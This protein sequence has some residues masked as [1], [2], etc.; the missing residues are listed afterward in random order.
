MNRPNGGQDPDVTA[1]EDLSETTLDPLTAA[2]SAK[3]GAVRTLIEVG[4]LLLADR[5]P[6]EIL[7]SILAAVVAHLQ[8]ERACVLS[9][10]GDGTIR[11]IAT[12]ALDLSGPQETWPLSRTALERVRN[13]GLALLAT[14][15]ISDPRF[16]SSG[17]V[18]RYSI[19]SVLCVPLGPKPARGLVYLDRRTSQS[20]FKRD[21]LE[22]LAAT[23]VHAASAL[24]KA[25]QRLQTV[26]ALADSAER[27]TLL[28][29]ELLRH[30][31]I[32]RSPKLLE[33]YDNLCRF[34][35]AGARVLLRGE[36]GTG[37]ELFARAYA[38]QSPRSGRAYVPVPIPALAP[39]LIE[40]ELFGHLRG[41]FTEAA[42][43]K[44][45]RLEV[46][47]GGVLF[48]DEIGDLDLSLQPKL[49]RFLDSGEVARVGDVQ[50]RH[51]DV[52]VVSATNRPLERLVQEE[53]FRGDLLARLGHSL[54]L[55]ALRERPEDVPLLVEHFLAMHERGRRRKEFSPGALEVLSAY[56]WEFNV[57][58]LQQVV[59]HA[60]CLVDHDVIQPDDLPCFVRTST[61]AVAR[62]APSAT[63]SHSPGPLGT[64]LAAVEKEH[65][66]EA[67]RY[68]EGNKRRAIE[69]LGISSETFYRRL[70][71]Y[72]L[73]DGG[74]STA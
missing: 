30:K 55:P 11:P 23:S 36:T 18:H 59:E 13:D 26:R 60:V 57:R 27:L 10:G 5:E 74:T 54:T 48:L 12:H 8:P 21:D 71:E 17:S 49:L 3:D 61:V 70:R 66:A 9:I 56:H 19:R 72:G 14:D 68:T 22:F 42:R 33:V 35:R 45:G 67:L 2:T 52:F 25:E 63:A 47:D 73:H 7:S 1:H 15:A 31:I 34:A 44:K 32:G 53:R 24:E 64:R 4:R 6:P 65:I 29:G 38:S 62:P 50:S 41:A 39:T 40:S 69:I 37:K 28:E 51:V 58:Q 46:A 43:D 16:E 20:P